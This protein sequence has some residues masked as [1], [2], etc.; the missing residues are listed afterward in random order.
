MLSDALG[1]AV[2]KG[3]TPD[4]LALLI[5]LLNELESKIK[6]SLSC[7]NKDGKEDI[8]SRFGAWVIERSND[9]MPSTP[10]E[11]T[12][13]STN[14]R[15]NHTTYYSN[16]PIG[17]SVVAHEWSHTLPQNIRSAETPSGNMLMPW[18]QQP[19][20]QEAEQIARRL[21]NGQSIC[22][23]LTG[24]ALRPDPALEMYGPRPGLGELLWNS[25]KS[26]F[27]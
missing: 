22:D 2:V 11:D 5:P 12:M 3:A 6:Q 26:L 17:F 18:G 8:L 1:L 24:E 25:L 27:H 19:W 9:S 20:E 21:S 7:C 15:G 16:T 23:L 13:M 4:E 10:E 14:G